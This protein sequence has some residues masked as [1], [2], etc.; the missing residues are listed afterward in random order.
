MNPQERIDQLCEQLNEHNRLYYME[1]HPIIS[2]KEFDDL[3]AELQLLEKQ[4]P[5]FVR[6]D[7]PSFRV[8]GGITKEFKTVVHKYPMLSL[9]NTYNTAEI[10]EFYQRVIKLVSSPVQFVCELKFDGVAISLTYKNGELFQAVTRG[11]GV[12]GDDVTTN[13]KTIKSIPLKLNLGNWPME[14]EVRGEIF[15]PLSSFNR[16]NSER[17]DI[18]ELPLANP[19]NAASGTLKMQDSKVVASRRL[20][21]FVYGLLGDAL[22]FETH[23]ENLNTASRWGFQVSE[24]TKLCSNLSEVFAYL[25]YWDKERKALPFETDGIVIKVNSIQQQQQLG[26]TAKSP[27]WAVAYKFKAETVCTR[28]ESISF[29]VGR[30]GA[31]TPVA[32]LTPVKLAGTVVKRASLHNADQIQRLD[33]RLGDWVFVEKGGEII[34]K[35]VGVDLT[36]RDSFPNEPFLYITH[37]PECD[38]VLTRNEGEAVHFCPNEWGCPPQMKGKIAHFISRR[39]MNIDGM[40]EETVEQFYDLGLIRT[41][42]DIFELT[43]NKIIGIERFAEK[44]VQNLLSGIENA[45]KIPFERVLFALGIRFVGETTAKKLARRFKSIDAIQNA[46]FTELVET[47]EVGEKIAISIISYFSNSVN[48][49]EINRLKL[50]G[51]QFSLSSDLLLKQSNVLEGKTFVVSGVFSKNSRDEIKNLIEQHGGKN[52]GSVSSKTSYLLAG[53]NMGPEKRKKAESNGVSIIS[54]DDFLQMIGKA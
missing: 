36:K 45:K 15:M 20:D 28:L 17:E 43:A 53:E 54:E 1:D 7:S 3:L 33:I 26:F 21:C 12:Q 49:L 27:R 5:E 6:A 24:H 29:H 16:I 44:S 40:G 30:T 51:L 37:C 2:D 23:F 47:E 41:S 13:V 50:S 18:G 10:E 9:G 52:V 11:D 35:V 48:I 39:A 25:N 19:R 22:Q 32:N 42:A 4:F 34:P 31:I 8:G 38:T 46:T 14:F